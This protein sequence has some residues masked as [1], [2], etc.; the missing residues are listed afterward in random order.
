MMRC[1]T[2]TNFATSGGYVEMT[3]CDTQGGAGTGTLTISGTASRVIRGG[4]V[5]II[6]HTNATT[7][8][9]GQ[10]NCAPITHTSGKLAL[11]IGTVYAATGTSNALSSAAGT[12][13][14]DGTTFLTPTNTN[15]RINIA[16]GVTYQIV[17]AKYDK[18]NSTI[19]GTATVINP[20]YYSI[21]DPTISTE[22]ATKNYVDTSKPK[23]LE[24]I[25][26]VSTSNWIRM[27]T[28]DGTEGSAITFTVLEKNTNGAGALQA[29]ANIYRTYSS[30]Y[31]YVILPWA[32]GT[33]NIAINYSEIW[34]KRNYSATTTL[35]G[36]VTW[37]GDDTS[38]AV[39]GATTSSTNPTGYI[40]TSGGSKLYIG[41]NNKVISGVADP[42]NA[43]DAAT[44][45]YVDTSTV[46]KDGTVAMTGALNM[47]ANKI[48]SVGDPT[49]AQDAQQRIMSIY[50]FQH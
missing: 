33:L 29:T 21:S 42:A 22:P 49:S 12:V 18:A 17:S 46:K 44:K 35:K 24:L 41:P 9:N 40:D 1:R 50:M 27:F 19:S 37:C 10:I 45:N 28:V 36:Y 32:G 34:V 13:I 30:S 25:N 26:P 4:Y 20:T 2:N 11:G 31:Q 8:I 14:I 6:T 3:D 48:T 47:G 23:Y 38:I 43:Q 16:A 5:G 39:D 15:A 7:S